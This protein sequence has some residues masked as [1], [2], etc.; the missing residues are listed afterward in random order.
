MLGMCECSPDRNPVASEGGE[1]FAAKSL[2]W[3]IL[4]VSPLYLLFWRPSQRVLDRKFLKP[5]GLAGL[6]LKKNA[7]VSQENGAI[8]DLL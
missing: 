4:P 2:F 5:E 6:A 3:N 1:I 7:G 8:R